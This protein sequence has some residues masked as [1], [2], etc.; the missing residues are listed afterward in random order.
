[1][2]PGSGSASVSDE[3]VDYKIVGIGGLSRSGKDSLAELLTQAGYMSVSLGDIVRE[4]CYERHKDKPDPITR[5]NTTETSNWLRETYGADIVMREG[6]KRFEAKRA[7][8]NQYMGVV[9][10]SIRAQVEV[11]FILAHGG[12]MVWVEAD[13]EVRYKRNVASLRE[14]ERHLSFEEFMAHE[15]EQWLPLPGIPKEAQMNVSYVKEHATTRI[16]N[17]GDDRQAFLAEAR[18]LLKI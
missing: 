13:D 5:A 8:G 6:L 15:A 7:G 17:N 16:V 9:L 2:E 14:G 3:R 10:H 18:R 4:Y 12:E 11:D 1:M